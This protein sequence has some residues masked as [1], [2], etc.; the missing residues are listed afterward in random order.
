MKNE[1][2]KKPKRIFALSFRTHNPVYHRI[3]RK[4]S[5]EQAERRRV[6]GRRM[7]EHEYAEIILSISSSLHRFIQSSRHPVFPSSRRHRR[8]SHDAAVHPI[9]TSAWRAWRIRQTPA[10]SRASVPA[11]RASSARQRAPPRGTPARL[12]SDRPSTRSG[13]GS[14][15]PRYCRGQ[16][17]R[18]I[19]PG[20][21]YRNWRRLPRFAPP[22]RSGRT[23]GSPLQRTSGRTRNVRRRHAVPRSLP[24]HGLRQR[25]ARCNQ[26]H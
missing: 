10:A 24:A 17:R 11:S 26:T 22:T 15:H 7:R 4:S 1:K 12:R 3:G 8:P 13:R 20:S 5:L 18:W 23:Q 16:T 25:P 19:C 2:N 9:T 6:R 14:R 21:A